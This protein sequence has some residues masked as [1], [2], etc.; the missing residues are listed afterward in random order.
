[1]PVI[2]RE[3]KYF[4]PGTRKL[5]EVRKRAERDCIE[6][7]LEDSDIRKLINERCHYCGRFPGWPKVAGIDRVD[8]NQGY[9]HG[10]VVPCCSQC[11]FMKGTLVYGVFLRKCK[12]ITDYQ[13]GIDK[14]DNRL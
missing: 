12:E 6:C 10:N 3:S 8:N 4:R 14:Y 1:M 13:N 9:I 5:K 2:C 11:N 7:N